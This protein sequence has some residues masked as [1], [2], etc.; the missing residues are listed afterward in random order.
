MASTLFVPYPARMIEAT[1]TRRELI[2]LV[3]VAVVAAVWWTASVWTRSEAIT[4]ASK[5]AEALV[6]QHSRLIDSELARFRLLPIVLGDYGDVA[7]VLTHPTPKAAARLS[8]KLALLA[9]KTGASRVYF[10]DWNGLAIAAS[11]I[12]EADSFVGQNFSFRPYFTD[13]V[14]DGSAEYYGAGVITKRSGL[15]IARRIDESGEA[16]GVVVVKYEF[17]TLSGTWASDPGQTLIVDANGIVLA[18]PD[19]SELLTTIRPLAPATRAAIRSTGQYGDA[20]LAPG[21]YALEGADR[22]TS[23]AGASMVHAALPIAGTDLRLLH[24][25]DTEPALAAAARRA[26]LVAL[27]AAPLLALIASALWWRISRAARLAADRRAL[28][29][30]VSERTAQLQDEMGHRALAD[31]RFRLAREELAQANRLAA[32]G[33]ITAGMMHEISQP[34][35]TIRTLSENALHHLAADRMDRVRASLGTA[36]EMTERIG[37]LMQEMRGFSRRGEGRVGPLPL[38]AVIAGTMLLMEDRIRKAGIRLNRSPEGLGTVFGDRVRLEQV[39]VNLLQNAVEALHDIRAP[40]IDLIVTREGDTM[41]LTVADNG[42]GIDPRL[43]KEVFQ[44]FVTNKPNGLGL[45]LRIA[46]DI[47]AD[48]GGSLAL[49]VSPLGGAAFVVTMR[50]A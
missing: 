7:E 10:L 32:L 35:A 11:N 30:A 5:E 19:P 24:L 20:A 6:R 27:A 40:Q 1:R 46:S 38:D 43:G 28:E 13:A 21:A 41:R 8:G 50:A 33:S 14:R 4:E 45:G 2:V 22:I 12:G 34:V 42:P 9:R 48:L 25:T 23:P 31:Q 29:A 49:G 47:M 17:D 18:A 16:F 39:L 44:P 15:F 37:T 36:I 26:T 3:L